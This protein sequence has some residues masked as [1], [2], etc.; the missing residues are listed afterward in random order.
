MA[1]VSDVQQPINN[2]QSFEAVPSMIS[3]NFCFDF[4]DLHMSGQHSLLI[5]LSL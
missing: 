2:L 5:F 1:L 4:E 3:S